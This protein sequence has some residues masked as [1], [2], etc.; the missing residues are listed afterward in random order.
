MIPESLLDAMPSKR[1]RVA[2][3]SS[4]TV[5]RR[6]SGRTGNKRGIFECTGDQRSIECTGDQKSIECT[7]DQKSIECTGDQ[8]S[9]ECPGDQR[10]SIECPGD[11]RN[12]IECPGDQRG[13]IECPGD[14]RGSIECS[15]DQRGRVQTSLRPAL[16]EYDVTSSDE[17]SN[18]HNQLAPTV[19]SNSPRVTG[20]L[21]TLPHVTIVQETPF[22]LAD[23]NNMVDSTV[24]TIT[25]SEEPIW[26]KSIPGSPFSSPHSTSDGS[27]QEPSSDKVQAGD[28]MLLCDKV[29]AGDQMLLCD[30]VQAGDQ[31]LLCDKMQPGD[32]VLLCFKVQA[33][34]QMLLCDKVQP[35]NQVLLCDK[36]EPGDQMRTPRAQLL[37]DAIVSPHGTS[38]LLSAGESSPVIPLQ[39]LSPVRTTSLAV[40][41]QLNFELVQVNPSIVSVSHE[42]SVLESSTILSSQPSPLNRC[43][44]THL[45]GLFVA[46][47]RCKEDVRENAAKSHVICCPMPNENA[48][49]TVH[50][51]EMSVEVNHMEPTS[52]DI[53]HREP[54]SVDVNHME[55][56]C[57]DVNHR[58]PPSF[59]VSHRAPS[60]DVNQMELTSV[61]PNHQETP[62]I[63]AKTDVHHGAASVAA[64]SPSPP[65]SCDFLCAMHDDT[66][67]AS[68]TVVPDS[69]LQRESAPQITSLVDTDG[70]TP[71]G[72]FFLTL[73]AP[74]TYSASTDPTTDEMTSQ[75]RKVLNPQTEP[76]C[77]TPTGCSNVTKKNGGETERDRGAGGIAYT[78][79]QRFVLSELFFIRVES[80]LYR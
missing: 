73:Y 24:N 32:Q 11:Q 12:S 31:M 61:G 33:G 28:Q 18:V 1:L 2:S 64:S 52:V 66:H 20:P 78:H 60:V 68:L 55:P 23:G 14:Q 6:T 44:L 29:Q 4:R 77:T 34:D 17:R 3:K 79:C 36:V 57:V 19:R 71:S 53:N 63:C 26:V 65:A 15:G 50:Q 70:T 47:H 69:L 21:A 25:H 46:A 9:I 51:K 80:F 42:P 45:P 41:R 59:D 62:V 67:P 39:N 8:K 16:Q 49:E 75:V 35:G 5:S 13:S 37:Q 10:S 22:T 48:I 76:Q 56:T 74:N 54:V 43:T 72:A 30:K 58:E 40:V 27:A 7:G 38:V